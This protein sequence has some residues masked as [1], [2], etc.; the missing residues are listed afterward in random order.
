MS[1]HKVKKAGS[2][3]WGA[4]WRAWCAIREGVTQKE[5]ETFHEILRQP[6]FGN[7]WILDEHG[8]PRGLKQGNRFSNWVAKGIQLVKHIWC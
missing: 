2:M 5:P 1:T 6:L 7:P 8:T 3:L 4:T